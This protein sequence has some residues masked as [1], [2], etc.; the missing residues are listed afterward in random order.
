MKLFLVAI[1]FAMSVPLISAS[2]L[3]NAYLNNK[4]ELILGTK[5]FDDEWEKY[6]FNKYGE[7]Y[8]EIFA[9]NAQSVENAKKIS[10]LFSKDKAGEV[11]YPSYIGGLYIN[12]NEDLVIQIVDVDVPSVKTAGRS[13]YDNVLAVDKNAI[14]EHVKYSYAELEKVYAELVKELP[15]DSS[16]SNISAIYTD[17]INNRV[18]VELKNYTNEEIIKFAQES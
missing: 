6:L 12:D 7:N 10:N 17:V 14:I 1:V 16:K 8:L 2:N 13:I 18:V 11:M 3:Y 5:E 4:T 15:N 9:R